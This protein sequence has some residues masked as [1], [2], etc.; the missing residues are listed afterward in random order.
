MNPA[1]IN[2]IT[3]HCNS[4]RRYS[5]QKIFL[6]YGYRLERRSSR[7]IIVET[8]N[9]QTTSTDVPI[10]QQQP[11]TTPL[12]DPLQK[13]QQQQ[14]QSS[15]QIQ[16][17][18]SSRT[19]YQYEAVP[20]LNQITNIMK[21]IEENL[22]NNSTDDQG[23]KSLFDAFYR[24]LSLFDEKSVANGGNKDK[25]Q[26]GIIEFIE[27]WLVLIQKLVTT[28]TKL[29]SKYS[30]KQPDPNQNPFSLT[31]SK[32]QKSFFDPVKVLFKIHKELNVFE[33]KIL[34]DKNQMKLFLLF[35]SQ[36][37][38][39]EIYRKISLN[40]KQKQQRQVLHNIYNTG[41]T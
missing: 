37:L 18:Q 31:S 14:K 4:N 24:V 9:I 25:L 3:L 39:G 5:L 10:N 38:T 23:I 36:I 11:Q 16:Q 41:Y 35:L 12:K 27:L 34:F 26:E 30:M 15:C 8:R 20:L 21:F 22:S 6:K 33:I 19:V 7:A 28:K 2:R 32:P 29:E 13:Q 1:C 40:V 17:Q